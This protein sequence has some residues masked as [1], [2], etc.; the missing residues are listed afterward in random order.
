MFL[1][2]FAPW[3]SG[4]V[5]HL[6]NDMSLLLES[7]AQLPKTEIEKKISLKDTLWKMQSYP[8]PRWSFTLLSLPGYSGIVWYLSFIEEERD[9]KPVD[10]FWAGKSGTV[11]GSTMRSTSSIMPE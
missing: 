3:E 7:S 2:I 6:Q 1:D 10:C 5:S 8:Q 4:E 9:E 11:C